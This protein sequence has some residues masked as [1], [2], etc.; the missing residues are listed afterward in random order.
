MLVRKTEP[1][2]LRVFLGGRQSRPQHLCGDWWIANQDM[3]SGAYAGYEV[4]HAWGEGG[5]DGKHASSVMPQ[6]LRWIW[7]DYP[8]PIS[9]DRMLPRRRVDILVK[10]W[11]GTGHGA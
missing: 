1:K 8:Q 6:A 2:P 5:H 3:A 9:Q 4:E 7:K 11:L 10:N